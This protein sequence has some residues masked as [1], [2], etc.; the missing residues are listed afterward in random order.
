MIGSISIGLLSNE[1]ANNAWIYRLAFTLKSNNGSFSTHTHTHTQ[2][3]ATM[4]CP[5]E[6]FPGSALNLII[7]LS[8]IKW[9][10]MLV[11]HSQTH[12]FCHNYLTWQIVINC[13]LLSYVPII[14]YLPRLSHKTIVTKCVYLCIALLQNGITSQ[15][16]YQIWSQ[17]PTNFNV[18]T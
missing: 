14:F 2:N 11:S 10:I 7:N 15:I 6:W 16:T 9:T 17:H 3:R 4:V 18:L 5:E 8:L 1:E 12:I 13:L